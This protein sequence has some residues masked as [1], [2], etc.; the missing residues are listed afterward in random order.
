M[1]SIAACPGKFFLFSLLLF[2]WL[3]SQHKK[4]CSDVRFNIWAN[5]LFH[6]RPIIYLS[7]TTGGNFCRQSWQR[8]APCSLQTW[9]AV[10]ARLLWCSQIRELNIADIIQPSPGNNNTSTSNLK[11]QIKKYIEEEVALGGARY[12]FTQQF[13]GVSTPCCQRRC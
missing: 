10:S 5:L 7:L 8:D 1:H 12:L 2:A 3:G 6:C 11:K 9:P 4:P 13:C